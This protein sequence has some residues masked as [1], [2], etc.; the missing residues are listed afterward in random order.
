MLSLEQHFI[1]KRS[2]VKEVSVSRAEERP[3]PGSRSE[4]SARKVKLFN[5]VL[6]CSAGLKLQ[7]PEHARELAAWKSC[8]LC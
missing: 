4:F 3:I 6:R 7:L 5:Q 2:Q 1:G 8:S